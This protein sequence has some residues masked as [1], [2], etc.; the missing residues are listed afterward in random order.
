MTGDERPEAFESWLRTDY[1][2]AHGAS[3]SDAF[4]AGRE[5]FRAAVLRELGQAQKDVL[6][7]EH[8]DYSPDAAEGLT[9]AIARVEAIK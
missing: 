6:T 9:L 3:A 1:V 4:R 5:A 8:D 7:V 2:M